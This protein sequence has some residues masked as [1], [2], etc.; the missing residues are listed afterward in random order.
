MEQNTSRRKFLKVSAALMAGLCCRSSISAFAAINDR[1]QLT[2]YH[3]HTAE[4]LRIHHRPGIRNPDTEKKIN[5]FFRDFRTGDVHS[6]D[7]RLMDIISV[8]RARSGSSGVI[9]VV[10]GYRS[11]KTNRLLRQRS[12]GVAKKSLHMEGRAIDLRIRNISTRHLR[13]VAIHLQT[14]GVGYYAKSD[15]VHLDTGDIRNW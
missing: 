1:Q 9:E 6:M 8:V 14:G 3:T 5:A 2:F 4:R 13:D 15:F 11:P 12:S 7:P 10:S